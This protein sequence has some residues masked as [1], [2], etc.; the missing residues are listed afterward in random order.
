MTLV[1][2]TQT[3]LLTQM[4]FSWLAINR[5]HSTPSYFPL[6]LPHPLPL[7]VTAAGPVRQSRPR[8]RQHSSS[9]YTRA[10]KFESSERINSIRETKGNFDSCN[11]CERLGTSRSHELNKS[12]FPFVS[13]I[14]FIRW[15]LSNFSALVH[16]VV[17][18]H[19]APHRTKP[20]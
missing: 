1:R 6:P 11:S 20:L 16:G 4:A 19:S 10:E 13:R 8:R 7:S 2:T 18:F 3:Q 14:E 15:K 5:P 17:I 12:K 9:P